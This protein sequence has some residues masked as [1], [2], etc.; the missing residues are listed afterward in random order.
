M[1]LWEALMSAAGA[2]ARETDALATFCDEEDWP[3]TW[4]A[5]LLR[6]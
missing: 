1:Q 4:R 6:D 3:A 2:P 5:V